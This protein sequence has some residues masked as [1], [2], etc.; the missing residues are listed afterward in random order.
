MR[1]SF[2][3]GGYR[4]GG[5]GSAP[6]EPEQRLTS[7]AYPN[8]FGGG[9]I[10]SEVNN[11]DPGSVQEGCEFVARRIPGESRDQSDPMSVRG[12]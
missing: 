9:A 10:K 3:G 5:S 7:G 4:S 8:L 1:A 6:V 12:G 11:F 2:C